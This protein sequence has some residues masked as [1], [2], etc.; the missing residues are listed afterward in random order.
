MRPEWHDFE[1][2]SWTTEIN[3]RSFIQHN[4]TPYLG[5]ESFL[6]GPTERTLKLWEK[7]QGTNEN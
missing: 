2:G 1:G 6:T 7:S 5:D 4:Y 3:V